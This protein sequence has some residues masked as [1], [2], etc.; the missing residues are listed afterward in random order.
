MIAHWGI[1]RHYARQFTLE[2]SIVIVGLVRAH[3]DT[4]TIVAISRWLFEIVA[5]I[6]NLPYRRFLIC[7]A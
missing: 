3:R 6:F 4:T 7:C 2:S 1:S 5:Q